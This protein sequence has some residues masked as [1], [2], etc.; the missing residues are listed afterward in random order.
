MVAYK[1]LLCLNMSTSGST[2]GLRGGVMTEGGGANA[3]LAFLGNL[4]ENKH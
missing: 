2:D 3:W 4:F 1:T